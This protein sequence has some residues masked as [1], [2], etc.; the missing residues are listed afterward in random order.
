[1]LP[2]STD[3]R[4]HVR[5][6]VTPKRGLLEIYSPYGDETESEDLVLP[7][8]TI[9]WAK[10][11]TER[12]FST[13]SDALSGLRRGSDTPEALFIE[14]GRYRFVLVNGIDVE[15]LRKA[16][17]FRRWQALI[18]VFVSTRSC[19]TRACPTAARLV[20]LRSREE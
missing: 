12:R 11:R 13:S 10:A 4:R 19:H 7:S 17:L 8:M 5:A 2:K 6:V 9:T 14:L 1:M 3:V 18:A 16:D 20:T 15:L